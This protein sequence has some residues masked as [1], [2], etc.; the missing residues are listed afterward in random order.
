M[1]ESTTTTRARTSCPVQEP[2]GV[3]LELG[4]STGLSVPACRNQENHRPGLQHH[5]MNA[6]L[7]VEYTRPRNRPRALQGGRQCRRH[8]SNEREECAAREPERAW[9]FSGDRR[10]LQRYQVNANRSVFCLIF[11]ITVEE[12]EFSRMSEKVKATIWAATHRL[13]QIRLL[14]MHEKHKVWKREF[15]YDRIETAAEMDEKRSRTS[16]SPVPNPLFCRNMVIPSHPHT[17]DE[18]T[19]QMKVDVEGLRM[20][21]ILSQPPSSECDPSPRRAAVDTGS[22]EPGTPPQSPAIS[23]GSGPE[24]SRVETQ[25]EEEIFSF[26]ASTDGFLH[27]NCTSLDPEY[28]LIQSRE[29]YILLQVQ[30]EVG[31]DDSNNA[32][33][34]QAAAREK[35]ARL[36]IGQQQGMKAWSTDQNSSSI[37]EDFHDAVPFFL[38]EKCFACI[39]SLFFPLV[40]F[41]C[42]SYFSA[43]PPKQVR[44][45]CELFGCTGCVNCCIKERSP[46]RFF[47]EKGYSLYLSISLYSL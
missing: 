31:T 11:K 15:G 6:R 14:L 34:S 46:S 21:I 13:G 27:S 3:S 25:I 4:Y 26:E 47:A 5:Q 36:P 29:E 24:A 38:Q 41:C 39:L 18:F 16:T 43:L 20:E 22:E 8:R 17:P 19:L 10:R 30:P 2:R 32:T 44:R 7:Y 37:G 23:T 42:L 1:C 45:R 9:T 12:R 33:T 40:F 28:I 35:S